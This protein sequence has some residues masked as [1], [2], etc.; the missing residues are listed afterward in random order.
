MVNLDE[1]KRLK[2]TSLRTW[3]MEAGLLFL[4]EMPTGKNASR[5]TEEGMR[6]GICVEKRRGEFGEYDAVMY[7]LEAQQL[8]M[9]NLDAIIA[10]NNRPKTETAYE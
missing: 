6:L 3:L 4:T 10:I 1:R 2:S 9:D 8:V 5:P 7:G